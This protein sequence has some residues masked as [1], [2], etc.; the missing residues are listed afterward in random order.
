MTKDL[1]CTVNMYTYMTVAELNL[2]QQMLQK[3]IRMTK[4]L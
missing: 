3:V 4:M 1:T 2:Q